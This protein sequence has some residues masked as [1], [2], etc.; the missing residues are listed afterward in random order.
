MDT[1]LSLFGRDILGSCPKEMEEICRSE[2]QKL[3]DNMPLEDETMVSKSFPRHTGVS[4]LKE[5]RRM[6]F[7]RNQKKY[8]VNQSLGVLALVLPENTQYTTW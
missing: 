2:R 6:L 8:E 3:I 4:P 1:V 7:S 5:F